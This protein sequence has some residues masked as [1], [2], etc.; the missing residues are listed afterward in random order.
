[1]GGNISSN[2]IPRIHILLTMFVNHSGP[3]I[4]NV[5]QYTFPVTQ[6]YLQTNFIKTNS[7]LTIQI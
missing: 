5:K 4:I 7:E 2:Y 6:N 1:M 3:F